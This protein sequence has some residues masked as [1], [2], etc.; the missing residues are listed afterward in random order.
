MIKIH[1]YTNFLKLS[2]LK[3]NDKFKVIEAQTNISNFCWSPQNLVI[4]FNS[5][6][7]RSVFKITPFIHRKK[8]ASDLCKCYKR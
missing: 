7:I 3:Y 1:P 2:L 4:N 8:E 6:N 5:L